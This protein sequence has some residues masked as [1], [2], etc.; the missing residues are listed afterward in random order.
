MDTQS[1][2]FAV[3]K[4]GWTNY[5]DKLILY[6]DKDK[7]VCQL[8]NLLRPSRSSWNDIP[9]KLLRDWELLA[10]QNNTKL[11]QR[12]KLIDKWLVQTERKFFGWEV[13][14]NSTVIYVVW[15]RK[16]LENK[17]VNVQKKR[18]YSRIQFLTSSLIN[19]LLSER[20][21]ESKH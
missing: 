21:L 4:R 17:V 18:G 5:W 7:Q 12:L 15:I 11:F 6:L 3:K 20:S 13:I 16:K 9:R 10:F 8:S 1:C 19:I 2:A 14:V